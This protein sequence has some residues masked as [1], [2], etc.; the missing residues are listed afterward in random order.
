MTKELKLDHFSLSTDNDGI[1]TI[2]MDVADAKVNTLSPKVEKDLDAIVARLESDT[3]I[4]GAIF[5][6]A[7]RNNFIAGADIEVLKDI[8]EASEATDLSRR[9]QVGFERLE[10]VHAELGKPIVA[11]IDGSCMGGGLE[12][13]LACSHRVISK[14]AK[15]ILSLPEVQLGLF[16]GAGGT[17]RLPK[18]I[19]LTGAL[20]MILTGRNIRHSK[21]VKIGLVDAAVPVS[22]LIEV[23]K[24]L[25]L[26]TA[27][28]KKPAVKQG[29]AR[30]QELAG[31]APDALKQLALESNPAGQAIVFK[32]AR[33]SLLKKT[34]GN[35]PGPEKALEVIRIGVQEGSTA[36]YA[37]ESDRFGQLVVSPEAKSLMS[38][39]FATQELKKHNGVKNKKIKAKKVERLGIIGGGLMGGGIAVVTAGKAGIPVRIKDISDDGVRTALSHVRKIFD[40]DVKR[41]RKKRIDVDRLMQTITGTTAMNGFSKVDVVVEAVFENL[42]VKRTVLR[43]VEACAT[44]GNN[45]GEYTTIFASNTSSLPISDIAEASA[46]PETVIGMHYFSPVEKMPLLEVITTDKTADWV[47]ATCVELG[48][49]QGKTV[50]VVGDGPGFYTTRILSP[51]MN[52]A[53]WALVEGAGIKQLDSSL[54]DWGFPVGPIILLDEVGIDVGAKVAK[55]TEAAFPGRMVAPPAMKD[56]LDDGRQGRKNDK[57]FYLYDNG[58]KGDVDESVY[59]VLGQT[60]KRRDFDSEEMQLRIGLQMVNEAALCLQEG[61]LSSPRDGDIG[62]IFGLG[63]PPFRGGPFSYVDEVGAAWVVKQLDGLAD[64]HGGRFATAQILRDYAKSGKKFR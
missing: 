53:A 23:A 22:M 55:V 11:A 18:L 44:A 16:P 60:A 10:A 63:F 27:L 7:K 37:A 29:F 48:K 30:L 6:S 12:L 40:K 61:I 35:Y 50:I 33:E 39:F 49:K 47:T 20:D 64:K 57:G 26:D 24:Q 58:K 5:T 2:V 34:R 54:M 32:K 4:V 62:A 51:Y 45:E 14:S 43:E 36:G 3:T 42:E 9:L 17:Q 25:A 15:T 28:G 13:A 59:E 52:E 31:E 38:I 41:R 19:G 21:A 46:H 1:A 56:I 8:K